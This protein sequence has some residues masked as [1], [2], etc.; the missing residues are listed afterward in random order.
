M[1]TLFLTF[2]NFIMR[3][4][5][6]LFSIFFAFQAFSQSTTGTY[7]Q[8]YRVG[9]E[10]ANMCDNANRFQLYNSTTSGNYSPEYIAGVM[11]G[12]DANRNACQG[13]PIGPVTTT[14]PGQTWYCATFGIFC[15]NQP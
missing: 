8:G 9:A 12:W 3:K 5:I 6:V 13:D 11:E 10:L 4:L 14:N 15:N 2:N 7:E 1:F